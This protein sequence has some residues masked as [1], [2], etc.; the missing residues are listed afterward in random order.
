MNEVPWYHP[1]ERM[2]MMKK[3]KGCANSTATLYVNICW[4]W[5]KEK[6]S[7]NS[8]YDSRRDVFGTV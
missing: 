6:A 7:L 1:D 5:T 4:Q 3:M 2:L 8:C